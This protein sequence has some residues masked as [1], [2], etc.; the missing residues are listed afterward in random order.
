MSEQAGGIGARQA[1]ERVVLESTFGF[2][3][4]P[5][6]RMLVAALAAR[7]ELTLA[8]ADDL[9]LALETILAAC[10]P[11][12]P[13]R[14]AFDLEPGRVGATVDGL[15][16]TLRELLVAPESTAGEQ[17]IVRDPRTAGGEALPSLRTIVAAV[18]DVF[19]VETRGSALSLR[20]EKLE[21]REG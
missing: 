9:Q 16:A 5:L 12:L 20:L 21:R 17:G 6:L 14:V 15:P 8:A 3:D 19:A 7:A 4:D 2:D 10:D 11:A 1:G 13:V 18:V